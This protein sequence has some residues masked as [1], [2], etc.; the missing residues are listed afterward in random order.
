MED[1]ILIDYPTM[2]DDAM[3]SV[4]RKA[5]VQVAK[6]GVLPGDHHF[7]ITFDTTMPGVEMSKALRANTRAR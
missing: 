5:L 1:E 7:F 3:R 6:E 2:I 4:V